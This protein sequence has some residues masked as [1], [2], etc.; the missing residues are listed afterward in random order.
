MSVQD[1]A[2]PGGAEHATQ[3]CDGEGV[4]V[5][6]DCGDT[7]V[8]RDDGGQEVRRIRSSGSHRRQTLSAQ[9]AFSYKM[10]CNEVNGG[11]YV[12]AVGTCSPLSH[13]SPFHS[14]LPISVQNVSSVS[15][16]SQSN[17]TKVLEVSRQGSGAQFK[18]MRRRKAN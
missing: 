6:A 18:D 17:Q 9:V 3:L 4:G 1:Q 10:Q 7:Q 8:E 2:V 16:F 13:E 14:I 5:L 15:L 12:L 11:L